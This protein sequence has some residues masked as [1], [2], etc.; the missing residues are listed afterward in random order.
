M[1]DFIRKGLA[2][3]MLPGSLVETTG[4]IAFVP[5]RDNPP[6]FQTA[7]AP[8]GNRRLSAA[9]RATIERHAGGD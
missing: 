8:P 1:V 7:L 3:G 2:I 9:T 6:Q 4:D 5:I